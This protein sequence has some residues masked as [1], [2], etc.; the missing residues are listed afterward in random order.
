M[1]KSINHTFQ[2]KIKDITSQILRRYL[3]TPVDQRQQ[4]EQEGTTL[5]TILG[6]TL[7]DAINQS[8]IG[9][10]LIIMEEGIGNMVMLTPVIRNLK[11]SHPSLKITV[12]CK[13][14]PGQVIQNWDLVDKIIYDFD[15][16]FYDL[17]YVTIWGHQLYTQYHDILKQYSKFTLSADLKT[18]HESI[19]NMS[20]NGFMESYTGLCDTHC[21]VATGK[22]K[23]ET[24]TLLNQFKLTDSN[25]IVF[26]D[27]ALHSPGWKVKKWP[28][29]HTLAELIRRKFPEYKIVLIGDKEDFEE[30]NQKTWPANVILDFMG[31]TNIPQLAYLIK[32]AKFYIGNDS[33]PTHIAAAVGTKTYALFAPTIVAKNKPLGKDVTILNKRLPCSPCQYTDRFTNCNCIAY[34]TAEEVYEKIFFGEASKRKTQTLL[35]GDFSGGALRNEVY[36]KRTL[37][38]MG[39]NVIQFD[40]RDKVKKLKSEIAMSYELLNTIVHYEPDYVLICGG[41]AIVPDILTEINILAPNT[42]L[43]NW[44][45]DN[46]GQVEGWFH[47]LSSICH[48][49]YWSTGDPTLLSQVF[50]QTQ[51]PCRFLPITPDDEMFK[52]IEGIEK[53]IDVLFVGTP[54]S[55]PRIKLLEYLVQNGVKVQIYGNGEW[56]ESLK[57]YVKPGVFDKEFVKLLNR[58]KIVLNTNIINTVPLYFSDRY[59]QPT[60]VKT[61]GLNQYIPALEDMFENNKHMV[62]FKTPEECLQQINLLLADNNKQTFISENGYELYKTKYT[63]AHMLTLMFEEYSNERKEQT[64][65]R[66]E[67]TD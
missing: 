47:R 27:T 61:V 65:E 18:F 28:H 12:W 50:A 11:A 6:S 53:D 15:Y 10:V 67:S 51:R 26:G 2:E 49:S 22:D 38:K 21:D 31:K 25:Y 34:H 32:G 3:A 60:A 48:Y 24:D 13:E 66:K 59:F 44:Y 54:H 14:T 39:H 23:E 1:H 56:P 4:L 16:S 36:I 46:R 45:V 63:L 30:A 7:V 52:P 20:I 42:K 62:F 58:A 55:E 41:Q 17:I 35:V 40:Y 57:Q 43:I 64:Q 29:Y 9:S 19:Q 5:A 8:R 33:G 37:E